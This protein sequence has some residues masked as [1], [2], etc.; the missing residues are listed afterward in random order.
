MKTVGEILKET[1]LSR[2]FTLQHIEQGTK[3]RLKFLEA[4]EQDDYPKLPSLSYAKGF[5]KNYAEFLGLNSRHILAFFRRQTEEVP[6][7]TLLPKGL[8]APLN[9]PFLRLTPGRFLTIILVGFVTVFLL[10]FGVQY[11]RLQ[12]PP[13]LVV[14]SPKDQLVT[15]QRRIDVLGKTD[16]DATVIVNGV[17]ALVRSDGRFFDQVQLSSGINKVTIVATSRW[18]KTT[19]IVREVGVQ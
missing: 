17:S 19:T 4:I 16:P 12:N 3:I 13:P 1:R 10:Y 5:V 7:S 11:L 9:Q 15:T 18:N 6:R 8:A 14:D 2:G